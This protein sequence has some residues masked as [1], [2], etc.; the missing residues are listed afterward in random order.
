MLIGNDNM[1]AAGAVATS[2]RGIGLSMPSDPDRQAEI[3]MLE[4]NITMRRAL[5]LWH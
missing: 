3:A 5:T 4:R 1:S 2:R